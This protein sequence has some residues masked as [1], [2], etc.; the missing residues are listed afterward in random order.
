MA[1]PDQQQTEEGP[2][3]RTHK[4]V[5]W[6]LKQWGRHEVAAGNEPLT[7]EDVERM[8][9]VDGGTAKGMNLVGRDLHGADLNFFNLKGADLRMAHLEGAYFFRANLESTCL[10]SANLQRASLAFA[11][12][13]DANLRETNLQDG[14]LRFANLRGANF[15]DA[16]LDGG[17]LFG[18]RIERDT[19]RFQGARWGDKMMLGEDL[20]GEWGRCLDPYQ[21]LKQWYQ[22]NGDYETAGKFHYRGWEC[23]RKLAQQ[24]WKFPPDVQGWRRKLT[25]RYE[26]AKQIAKHRLYRLAGGYGEYPGRV[27]WAGAAVIAF[28]AFWYF[29]YSGAPCFQAGCWAGLWGGIWQSLYFSGAS[30]TALGYSLSETMPDGWTRYLGVVESLVGISLIA[31]FL[32]TFTRKMTR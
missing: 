11:N 13:K 1:E 24:E 28:F 4:A 20:A 8:N 29:P 15:G 18:A 5:D 19:T 22:H 2:L 23:K 10:V 17:E 30:F 16:N 7:H 12:L 21:A 32:V 6:W 27:L 25:H 3:P 31:L 26:S 9:Q 14:N